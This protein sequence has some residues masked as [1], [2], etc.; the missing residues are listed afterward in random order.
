MCAIRLSGDLTV[1]LWSTDRNVGEVTD[2]MTAMVL[3]TVLSEMAMFQQLSE[4]I[5]MAI[6]VLY[7]P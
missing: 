7:P 5:H 4:V 3:P 2:V 1:Q 6:N